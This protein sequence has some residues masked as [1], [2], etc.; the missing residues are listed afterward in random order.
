[1]LEV[2][3]HNFPFFTKKEIW[4]YKG[5][6]VKEGTYTSYCYAK[7]T[8]SLA[9]EYEL[10]EFTTT[11]ALNKKQEELFNS[12]NTTFKYH[13]RKAEKINFNFSFSSKPSTEECN[14]LIVSFNKFA[15][16]K[17]ISKINKRRIFAL[18]KTN[19]I[20]FTKISKE[21]IDMVTHV[22]LFDK[23]HA[24]LMHAFHNLNYFDKRIRGYANKFLHWKD[25]LL[26]KEMDIKT[27]DFGGINP[28]KVPGISR[29]KLSYGGKIE[30]A[31]SYI[32]IARY[33]RPVFKLYK[34]IRSSG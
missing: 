12:I 13:I 7:D 15:L 6:P 5:E 19:N 16:V 33:L 17:K 18:Q 30:Q 2:V 8:F 26:F 32:H 25:I 28:M 29:F 27:Y 10:K 24:L 11:I 21:N 23:E 14:K 3:T 1:M 34:L 20:I 31:N 22:Y 4:F 9:F